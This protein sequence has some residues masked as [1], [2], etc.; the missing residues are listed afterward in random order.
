MSKSI[1]VEKVCTKCLESKDVSF[2][3]RNA[4]G[5]YKVA[6]R[7][8]LCEK[9]I[10]NKDKDRE[11]ARIYYLANREKIKSNTKQWKLQNQHKLQ[12]SKKLHYLNNSEKYKENARNWESNNKDKHK[13]LAYFYCATRRSSQKTATPSW[14]DIEKIK[15]IYFDA[16]QMRG[17]GLDVEVDHIIPLIHNDVC[18]LHVHNNL[19]IISKLEN[20]KKGNRLI[21]ENT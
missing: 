14:A 7:C 11:N 20:R 12:T 13:F 1:I 6:S 17:N 18:G 8:K 9:T 10:R 19:R 4:L 5:K 21:A 16:A 15:H 3:N 2:F